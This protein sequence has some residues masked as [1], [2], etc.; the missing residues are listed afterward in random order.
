MTYSMPIENPHE[1]YD[2]SFMTYSV[3]DYSEGEVMTVGCWMKVY[4]WRVTHDG[5]VSNHRLLIGNVA[6]PSEAQNRF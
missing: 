3:I 5:N 2:H 1:E 4:S 6:V